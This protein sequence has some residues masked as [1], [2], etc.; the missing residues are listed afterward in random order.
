MSKTIGVAISTQGRITLIDTLH[1]IVQQGLITGDKI[2]VVGDGSQMMDTRFI[3][4]KFGPQF[5]YVEREYD[6][7]AWGHT[8]TNWAY[9]KLHRTVDIITAQ[10]DDDI[11]APRAFDM[12]RKRFE[13][14]HGLLM[15]RVSNNRWGILWRNPV[16]DEP[17][18]PLNFQDMALDGHCVWMPGNAPRLAKLG[19]E[20]N[21]DQKYMQ[22]ARYLFEDN[23]RWCDEIGSI[24]RP[25]DGLQW[26]LMWWLVRTPEQ[27]QQLRVLRNECR[28]GMTGFTG[29]I[30]EK[31]QRKWW[32]KNERKVRAYLFTVNKD[33]V[34]FCLVRPEG[35]G[36]TATIGVGENF[37]RNG[38]GREIAQFATIAA[39]GD[40]VGVA[41]K[42]NPVLPLDYEAGWEKV[43]ERDGLVELEM[44]W[45]PKFLRNGWQT[46]Q[47]NT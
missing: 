17:L 45:P 16:W 13:E 25:R 27:V 5:T 31:M 36:T 23:T 14:S 21:G 43:G 3:V 7:G 39:Q 8:Q 26:R 9:D 4:K 10:D 46:G 29:I 32:N 28:E 18:A 33:T 38:Y 15:M 1:S 44:K 42:D 35:S 24:T 41:H 2:L 22:M 20:Y 37:R 40:L 11:F 12:V 19:R 30:T 6:P 47:K 34:G